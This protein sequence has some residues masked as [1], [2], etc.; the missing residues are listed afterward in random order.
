MNPDLDAWTPCIQELPTWQTP[1]GELKYVTGLA[2]QASHDQ[3][4]NDEAAIRAVK[5]SIFNMCL[6][7]IK[8]DFE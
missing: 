3:F 7:W 4:Y 2:N 8:G 6:G 1:S 5:Q